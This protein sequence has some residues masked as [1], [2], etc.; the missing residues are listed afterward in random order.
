EGAGSAPA[1]RVVADPPDLS[2]GRIGGVIERPIRAEH[3]RDNTAP[4][5]RREQRRAR[6]ALEVAELEDPST[7]EVAE[8]VRVV[9]GLRPAAGRNES[10]AR[11]R[12]AA[13]AV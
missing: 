2:A 4:N 9:E 12:T 1:P 10:S 7:I 11:D 5:A 8:E 3:H 13:V 6:G